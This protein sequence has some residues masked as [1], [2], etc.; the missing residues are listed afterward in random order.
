ML[1]INFAM[2]PDAIQKAFSEESYASF[3]KLCSDV[4]RGTQLKYTKSE[5]N[6]EI[7]KQMR[8][9]MNLSEDP[10]IV[11]VRKALNKTANREAM[12]EVISETV[13]DTLI[14]GFQANPWF[15]AY[16]DYR[17]LALGDTNS[18]YVPD[19][20]ELV[21]SEVASS[22][23][24]IFRQRLGRGKEYSVAVKTYGAKVY[25]EAERFLMGVEDWTSLI[26]RITKAYTLLIQ[27]LIH[28]AVMSAS[29]SLPSP[30]QWNITIQMDKANRAK[31]VKL[32]S[33]VSIASG[34]TA[35]LMGTSVAL[36]GLQNMVDADIMSATE[37][38]DIYNLGRIGHFDQYS[39]VE[40]PQAFVNNDTSQYLYD[41][42]KLLVMPGTDNKFVKW[43]DEGGTYIREIANRD[44]LQDHT[45]EYEMVRK[46][47]LGVVL[48]TRFGVVTIGD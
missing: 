35:V 33:D 46:M 3:A 11:E 32:L 40:I 8:K 29:A 7:L 27:T 21:I 1:K 22:N 4:V 18:F 10:T 6:A 44:T 30:N 25:M 2:R 28:N 20:T 19:N 42:T 47:G 5:A 14:S 41:D 43:Y 38:E 31:L 13:E 24:D 36:S 37:K 45:Y 26:A 15:N 34:S 48:S 12:F 39:I 16:V 17:S 9:V 23:H